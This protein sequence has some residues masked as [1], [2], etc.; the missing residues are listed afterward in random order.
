MID[1]NQE[2]AEELDA[3]REH[4]KEDEENLKRDCL[5]AVKNNRFISI[6]KIMP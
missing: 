3:E 6:L 5:L 4:A 2:P 1:I